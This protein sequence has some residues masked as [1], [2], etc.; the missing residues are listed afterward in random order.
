M[1][2][3]ARRVV[4]RAL[5]ELLVIAAFA[6]ITVPAWAGTYRPAKRTVAAH[7][8][9]TFVVMD[10]AK[11]HV[12]HRSGSRLLESG[13]ATGSLPGSMSASFHIGAVVSGS[14]T[15]YTSDGSINGH[16]TAIAHG[17]GRYESFAGSMV[18]TGGTGRYAHAHGRAGMYGT[19]D[20]RTYAL[21]VQT[22]GMLSD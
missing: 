3:L 21:V 14:F 12:V 18:A 9:G 13:V 8:A 20:R 7:A 16:G 4:P 15:F 1:V 19:F 17:S 11:L 2:K 22:T 5:P 6:G 10:T